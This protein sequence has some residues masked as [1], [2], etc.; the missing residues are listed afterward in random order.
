MSALR[1]QSWILP[2]LRNGWN[3]NPAFAARLSHRARFG[4]ILF[5]GKVRC[6]YETDV[7]HFVRS[8]GRKREPRDR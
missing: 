4:A 7:K 2:G 6:A 1:G 8:T 5:A 3:R